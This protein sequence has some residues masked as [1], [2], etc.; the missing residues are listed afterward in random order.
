MYKILYLPNAT[1]IKY[2]WGI[3]LG[4]LYLLEDIE[5][6]ERLITSFLMFNYRVRSGSYT[7]EVMNILILYNDINPSAIREHFVI[8]EV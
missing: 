2:S 1:Y 8:E 5:E 4:K 7:S 6:A 3:N